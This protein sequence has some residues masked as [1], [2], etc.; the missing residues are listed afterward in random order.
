M[1]HTAVE[2][3][4]TVSSA[5]V[6]NQLVKRGLRNTVPYRVHAL[7]S[8]TERIVG[9]AFTLR[10]IP[11]REDIDT[12]AV[13]SDPT[14][15]QRVAVER[16]PAG[17]VLVVD[18]RRDDRAASA[19][20]ILMTRLARRGVL[21]IVTDGAIRDYPEIDATGIAV[22]AQNHTPATNLVAHHAID[23]DIPIGCGG[24]AVYPGDYVVADRDGVVIVPGHLVDEVA[25]DA[26]E[27]ERLERY[28]LGRVKNGEP[29]IG[30]YPPRPDVLEDYHQYL[31][32]GG[33]A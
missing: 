33:D 5:T 10:L 7:T 18:S 24:V 23:M 29:V 30:V 27:Q 20:E 28:L 21:A 22:F 15:A 3:L 2:Q 31:A 17:S 9:P 14:N 8:H 1:S 26:V 19:G 13:F 12:H 4:K 16:A 11:S 6:Q 25:H 32:T